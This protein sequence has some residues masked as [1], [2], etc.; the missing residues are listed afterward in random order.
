MRIEKENQK[1]PKSEI[2]EPML[3]VLVGAE[4]IRIIRL[5]GIIVF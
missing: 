1:S 2:T 4:G 3:F 5:G